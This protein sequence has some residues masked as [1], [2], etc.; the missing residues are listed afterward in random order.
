MATAQLTAFYF[1]SQK[2]KPPYKQ[3]E[4][5]CFFKPSK[6]YSPEVCDTFKS[7]LAQQKVPSWAASVL[8]IVDLENG[9]GVGKIKK[10]RLYGC[11]GIF[12]LCPTIKGNVLEV[13]IAAFDMDITPGKFYTVYNLDDTTESL[14]IWVPQDAMDL[15]IDAEYDIYLSDK[16]V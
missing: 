5:F 16:A 9:G 10:P 8:P 14:T 1:N 12:L 2:A 7:L 15:N 3:L 6:G 11:P 13:P 4:D